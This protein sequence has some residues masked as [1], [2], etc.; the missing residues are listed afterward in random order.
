[1]DHEFVG[2]H[3]KNFLKFYLDNKHWDVNYV[4]IDTSRGEIN[5]VGASH[6][7]IGARC[8]TVHSKYDG[9]QITFSKTRKQELY[10][11]TQDASFPGDCRRG[12]FDNLTEL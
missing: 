8:E 7:G 11:S 6:V 3:K 5:R 1:M 12:T 2:I 4:G 10:F 9:R